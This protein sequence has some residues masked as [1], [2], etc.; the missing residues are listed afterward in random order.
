MSLRRGEH[1]RG[2]VVMQGPGLISWA[3]HH[4][5]LRMWS[6]DAIFAILYTTTVLSFLVYLF[7]SK[8]GRSLMGFVP[9]AFPLSGLTAIIRGGALGG[10]RLKG[11]QHLRRSLDLFVAEELWIE[12]GTDETFSEW[13]NS[14]RLT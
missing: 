5:E 14:D 6:F 9:G 7:L 11:K 13:R 3:Y 10:I 8:T 1:L 2:A 12:A 4:K